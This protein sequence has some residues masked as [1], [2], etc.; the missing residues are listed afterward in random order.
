MADKILESF[1]ARQLEEGMALAR[2]SDILDLLPVGGT[3]PSR[4]LAEYRCVGA[5]RDASSVVAADRFQVGVYFPP[6]YL[7][8]VD[9]ALVLTLLA[10]AQVWHPNVRAPFIC[11]GHVTPGTGLVDLLHRVYEILSF[12]KV[13]MREDDALNR[14]AC[15]WAR[16][17]VH[18]FPLDPRPLAR[19]TT[20][21]QSGP[22]AEGGVP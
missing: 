14:E 7:R 10:P 11:A 9:P 17:N 18:R 6:D 22:P 3:P 12:H 8:T 20:Q 5:V 21:A 16:A 15:A 1:L 13:N 19:R 4:Y 2:G